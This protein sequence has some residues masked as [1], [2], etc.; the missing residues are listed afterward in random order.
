MNSPTKPPVSRPRKWIV[1]TC[2]GRVAHLRESLPTWLEKLPTWDPIVVCCDDPIAAEYAAG[3][4]VLARRGI[5][6]QAIQ[7]QY[8]NKIEALRVGVGIA[9]CDF[10]PEGQVLGEEWLALLEDDGDDGDAM[11]ALLDADTIAT[12]RTEPLLNSVGL[13]DVGMCGWGTRDDM[14]ILIASVRALW[15]GLRQIPKGMFEGY[16]PED[17]S[18]RV[19]VW[20]QVKKPF[21][22]LLSTNWVRKAHTDRERTRFYAESM[23]SAVPANKA[24]QGEL[25]ARILAPD[26]VARCK[27]DCLYWPKRIGEYVG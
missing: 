23:R 2:R 12:S 14:G 7:G 15:G 5:V 8:F 17:A 26:E 21:V 22:P 10:Y 27:A 16:G 6:V 3:E 13:S 1:T 20:T 19:A 4:L 18:L 24:A 25:M 9:A 11:V